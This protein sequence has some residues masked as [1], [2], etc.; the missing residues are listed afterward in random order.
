MH[1]ILFPILGTPRYAETW[2]FEIT[3]AT[4]L[5]FEIVVGCSQAAGSSSGNPVVLDF[6]VDMGQNWHRVKEDCI[7][8]DM[9]CGGYDLGSV[10]A[11][12]RHSKW[13]RVTVYLPQAAV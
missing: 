7:P 11:A 2:D 9:G 6:S 8:P 10:Y 4:F 13:T 1:R 12:D 5:Q 3:P